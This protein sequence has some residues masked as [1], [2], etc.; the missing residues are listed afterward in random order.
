M[1]PPNLS[2]GT[3]TFWLELW[4]PGKSSLLTDEIRQ[5]QWLEGAVPSPFDCSLVHRGFKTAYRMRGHAENAV[6][7]A[8][9]LEHHPLIE[10]VHYPGLESH[11][12]RLSMD[13]GVDT[14]D[15]RPWHYDEIADIMRKIA[16]A[17]AAASDH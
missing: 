14:H 7:V 17:P 16:E 6:R 15:F 10:V 3:E 2:A 11:P 8:R 13:V 12:Q 9:A 4:L 5:I 1:A